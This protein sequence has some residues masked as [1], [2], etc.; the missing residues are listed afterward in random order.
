MVDIYF[1]GLLSFSQLTLESEFWVGENLFYE[2]RYFYLQDLEQFLAHTQSTL[3]YMT[4]VR[5]YSREHTYLLESE[6]WL[7]H[8]LF[9]LH[10]PLH[11]IK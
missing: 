5:I 9:V 4:V 3:L 2:V 10:C 11:I 7:N 6:F 8:T 1:T